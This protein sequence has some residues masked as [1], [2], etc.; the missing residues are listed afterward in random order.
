MDVVE[1][2][3][4]TPGF[5]FSPKLIIKQIENK[6]N[7]VV[8]VDKLDADEVLITVPVPLLL[9]KETH[10]ENMDTH[11]L[12]AL[13]VLK[14]RKEDSSK[15]IGTFP[16]DY[17]TMPLFWPEDEVKLLPIEYQRIV[18][19]QKAD[20]N[21]FVEKTGLDPADAAWAWASVNTRCLYWEDGGMALV[22][23][24]DYLNH[25]CNAELGLDV[26]GTPE[27]F[28]VKTKRVYEIGEEISF[29][30]GPHENG[31]LLAHYGFMVPNNTWDYVFVDS[32][33]A[34]LVEH[35][36]KLLEDNNCWGEWTID[37]HGEPDFRT[38]IALA[39]LDARPIEVSFMKD[40]ILKPGLYQTT[41]SEAIRQIAAD[42]IN[43]FEG[44]LLNTKNQFIIDFYNR[45]LEI[46]QKTLLS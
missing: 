24:V 16:D 22:P 30:Y 15:W 1:S 23:V 21:K 46:L 28:V 33:M 25:V 42:L 39:S 41:I 12:L 43:E 6:G 2:Y 27:G 13:E 45:R 8:C 3:A 29:C 44:K 19:E 34:P 4:Q 36:K 35:K 14:R 18:A 5:F 7:S 17:D 9:K 26:K 37:R 10:V 20:I 11:E 32:V 38:E 40:G 31:F